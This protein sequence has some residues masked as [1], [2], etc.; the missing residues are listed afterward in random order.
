MLGKYKNWTEWYECKV[1]TVAEGDKWV[2][3]WDDY[4]PDDT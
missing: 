4:D 3:E 2:V 1:V